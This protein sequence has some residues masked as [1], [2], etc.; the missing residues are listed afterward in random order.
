MTLVFLLVAALATSILI[1]V[2]AKLPA[3]Q[4]AMQTVV[5]C[6]AVLAFYGLVAL[7]A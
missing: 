2:L 7:L 5:L 6:G 3:S 4:L 1:G